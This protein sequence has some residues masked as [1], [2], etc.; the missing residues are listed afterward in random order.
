MSPRERVLAV[1]NRKPCDRVPVINPTSLAT[2]E[3]MRL[4]NAYFPNA[5]LQGDAMAALAAV[6]HDTLGFDSV[7]PYFSV[8]AEAAALGCCMDWGKPDSLPRVLESPGG[9]PDDFVLPPNF[10]D[11]KPVKTVLQAIKALKKK[12]GAKVAVIGKVIGP[13]TLAYHLYGTADFLLSVVLEPE[14]VHRYLRNLAKVPLLFAQAQFEAGA[15]ILTWADHVTADLI[16]AKSYEEFLLP[17]HQHCNK[18]LVK[19]GPVILHVCGPVIDRLDLFCQAGFEAFH[20]DS[21]N[22]ASVAA[23]IAG[24]RLILAGNINNP[25]TLLGGTAADIKE[26]VHYALDGGIQLIAP[27]CALPCRVANRNLMEIVRAAHCW[28][29]V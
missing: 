9:E 24:E 3:S 16:S 14:K 25:A 29:A 22:D 10:L 2:L 19:A 23:G 17:V 26:A 7:T 4:A 5:H 20:L 15:D 12:Y 8:H 6:G 18:Q 1:F 21:R 11:R 28:K 13:W 27:E